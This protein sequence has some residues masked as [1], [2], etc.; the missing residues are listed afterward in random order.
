MSDLH[1]PL[2]TRH[3]STHCI[4]GVFCASTRDLK[5]WQSHVDDRV[6]LDGT[7]AGI[8]PSSI[9][10]EWWNAMETMRRMA[11]A[12]VNAGR[13]LAQAF[14]PLNRDRFTKIG[15]GTGA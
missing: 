1:R 2:I 14:A 12:Y 5:A 9:G 6:L 15:G 3:G 11:Q 10:E 4:C 13:K 8:N 7:A